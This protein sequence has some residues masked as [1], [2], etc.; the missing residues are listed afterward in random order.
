MKK[1]MFIALVLLLTQI[2]NAGIRPAAEKGM[3]LSYTGTIGMDFMGVAHNPTNDLYYSVAGGSVY[4]VITFDNAG[5]QVATSTDLYDWRSI[6]WN[7]DL[8]RLEGNGYDDEGGRTI[9]LNGSGHATGAISDLWNIR[10]QPDEQ[11]HGSY[12]WDADEYIYYDEGNIYRYNLGGLLGNYTLNNIPSDATL[13]TFFVAYTGESGAE[14][15]VYDRANR[16]ALF[17]SKTTGNYAGSCQLPSDAHMPAN[18][19]LGF[20]NKYL[21]IYESNGW[22]GYLVVGAPATLEDTDYTFNIYDFD[23]NEVTLPNLT[24]IR[25]ETNVDKGTLYLDA[26]TNGSYDAGEELSATSE[27]DKADIEN[28]KLKFMPVAEDSGTPYTSFNF[29]WHNGTSYQVDVLTVPIDV[30]A[31]NDVPV[32]TGQ[33]PIASNEDTV[34]K[35]VL[36]DLVVTD[37]DNTYPTDFSLS[38]VADSAYLASVDSNFTFSTDTITPAEN[39]NGNLVV[40]V[41]VNDGAADSD[42]FNVNITVDPVNDAPVITGQNPVT[43]NEDTPRKLVYA[44]LIVTDIDNNDPADFT[45]VPVAGTNYTVSADTI[46]PAENFSGALTV[47]V[48]ISDGTDA[49]NSFDMTVTVDAVNDVPVITGQNPIVIAEEASHKLTLADLTVADPDNTYPADFTL[50]ILTGSNYTV[51][52]DT[53]FAAE[54]FDGELTVPVTVNDGA[55]DSDTFDVAITV[56]PVNDAPVITS[57]NPITI[58]EDTPR[59]IVLSDLVISDPDNSDPADFTISVTSGTNYTV[60]V[61]TIIPAENFSGTLTV[62][63]SVDDG[64]VTR[65][66]SNT[67]NL[68][69]TVDAVNDVPVITGQNAITIIEEGFHKLVLTDLLVTDPDNTYPDDFTLAILAGSNYTVMVDTIVPA[70]NFNGNLTVPV[71]VNDGTVESDTFDVA[72]NV[73]SVNDAPV[74]TGQNPVTIPEDSLHVITLNDLLVTDPDNTYPVNFTLAVSVGDNYTL[75]GDTVKPDADFNGALTVPVTVN[76]Q[77]T[78]AVSNTYNFTITVSAVNDAPYISKNEG[79]T[80]AEGDTAVVSNLKLAALDVDNDTTTLKFIITG[81]PESGSLLNGTTELNI[82]DQFTQA[83]LT[84]NLIS[85]INDGS[86]ALAD[87]FAFKVSDDNLE[88]AVDHFIITV[89]PENDAPEITDQNAVAIPED[90]L[91]VITLNDLVVTDPDNN[92]PADFVLAVSAGDNYTLAGDTIK[93]DAN[94]N[95]ALTV[96]VTVNDQV[97]RAVSN[98][99]NFTITVNPVNDAPELVK[100]DSLM[101]EEGMSVVVDSSTIM[102][103]DVDNDTLMLKIT[104]LPEHGML[105]KD[106]TKLNLNDVVMYSDVTDSMITYIHDGTENMTDMFKFKFTD[107]TVESEEN[108]VKINVT[109]V[110]DAP[111]II[112]YTPDTLVVDLY[113]DSIGTFT[114][115]AEDVDGDSLMYKWM[116]DDELTADVTDSVQV[117]FDSTGTYMLSAIVSDGEA[118][119]TVKWEVKVT[120]FVG[121][122]ENLPVVTALHQNY[123]NPFN[124][125]TSINFDLATRGRVQI[126]IYNYT[127]QVVRRLVNKNLEQGRY[128]FNWNGRDSNGKALGSGIYFYHM[129]TEKFNKIRRAVMIK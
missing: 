20:A 122:D 99:F 37:V 61:D 93:P 34:Y 56:T 81:L 17:F 72:I 109:P 43:I 19:Y 44:D 13:T 125:S 94:F 36:S 85:Y 106:T 114:I 27:V 83:D 49:S 39:Y 63:V 67:F 21:W 89:T 59:K 126:T 98:T 115:T 97:V 75:A 71:T 121:I 52:V 112:A 46:I 25:I 40:P 30:F 28:G 2:L 47:S 104:M 7:P 117:S 119:D 23:Y 12:D 91:Y 1:T 65:E 123:P 102:L 116:I 108:T 107:G 68:T 58:N 41:T 10:N 22:Q 76:D 64:V 57:Q 16:R 128:T 124:P 50:S 8:N 5:N 88:T 55:A 11:S 101:A 92:Y 31:V 90:S 51:N 42:T 26:N 54:N 33:N 45:V 86:E 3:K 87:T 111:E 103:T 60:S 29:E 35:L 84:A 6:W 24:K 53:I 78:R 69:V 48:T 96:P 100:L 15:L 127:G 77:V 18:Y 105:K 70:E 62:P 32:I 118:A 14:I 120:E 9:A 110:N 113:V 79:L 66:A 82:N 38:I 74:I 80:V 95:G 129:K 4:P 73:T